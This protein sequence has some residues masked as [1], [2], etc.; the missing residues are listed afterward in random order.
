[1]VQRNALLTRENL[2]A[3]HNIP[4]H[5]P[6]PAVALN[7]EDVFPKLPSNAFALTPAVDALLAEQGGDVAQKF[8]V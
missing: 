1:M 4:R 5:L 7:L 6:I 8:R 2:L 3:K